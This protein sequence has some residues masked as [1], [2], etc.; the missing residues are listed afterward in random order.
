[1][2]NLNVAFGLKPVRMTHGGAYTGQCREYYVPASDGTALFVGDPVILAGSSDPTATA[3]S[4]TIATAAGG[5]RMTGVVVGFRPDSTIVANG[6]YRAASTA[7]Y[8]LVCDDP[9]VLYEIQDDSVGGALAAADMGLNADLIAG[10][11]STVTKQSGWM[12]DTSTKA[13][14]AT[15]QLRM[16]SLVDRADVEIGTTSKVLVRPNLTTEIGAVGSTGV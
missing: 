15:L 6:G 3:P 7:A 8:V 9:D 2:A 1:M 11:G 12:L 10:T 14:T 4:V 5:A 16:Y 13:T